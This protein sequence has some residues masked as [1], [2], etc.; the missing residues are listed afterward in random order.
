MKVV[1]AIYENGIFRPE[2][3][4]ELPEHCRVEFEPRVLSKNAAPPSLDEVY[5]VL[6]RRFACGERDVA[7]RHNEHQP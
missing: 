2:E 7:Q 6:N 5:A 3:P 1:H 4:V